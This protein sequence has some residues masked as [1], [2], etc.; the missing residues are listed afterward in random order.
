MKIHDRRLASA[1]LFT[2]ILGCQLFLGSASAKDEF[3]SDKAFSLDARKNRPTNNSGYVS[4]D[5]MLEGSNISQHAL[6]LQADQAERIG[7]PDRAIAMLE[8]GVEMDPKDIDTRMQLAEV[9]ERKLRAQKTRDPKLYNRTIREFLKVSRKA[10]YDDEKDKAI[11]HIQKLCGKTPMPFLTSNMFL[12][13]VLLAED[14]TA[15]VKLAS[16]DRDDDNDG[17]K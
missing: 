11:K 8:R 14:G 12:N 2:L 15:K 10:E 17:I 3:D 6:F 16:D 5:Q 7:G 4:S 9:L 1:L 13:K